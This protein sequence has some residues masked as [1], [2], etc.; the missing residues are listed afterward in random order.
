MQRDLHNN[1]LVSRALAPVDTAQTNNTA[2][3]SQI[4]D[5][6]NYAANEF[7]GVTGTEADADVTTTVLLEESAASDMSGANTVA[8]GDTLGTAS[9]AQ[10][11]FSNDNQTLKIGY[12]GSKRYIRV[13]I[14]PANNT[15]NFTIAAAWVQGGPRVA[16]KSTQIN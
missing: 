4:L 7:V 5:T 15:G 1:I 10:V 11:N 9:G 12:I 14:T 3:V 8:A 6:A 16:P 13:T 2:M